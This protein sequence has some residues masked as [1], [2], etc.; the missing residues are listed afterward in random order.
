MKSIKELMANPITTTFLMLSL[1][2]SIFSIDIVSQMLNSAF[3]SYDGERTFYNEN[4]SIILK[5]KPLSLS[6]IKDIEVPF[7][8]E[9]LNH[10][11]A[12][13]NGFKKVVIYG[14]N[15]YG[16]LEKYIKTQNEKYFN[17]E[18]Y[19]GNE[20]VAIVGEL[21]KQLVYKKDGIEYIDIKGESFRVVDYISD[22]ISDWRHGIIIPVN[23]LSKEIY[24]EDGT[25]IINIYN[26]DYNENAQNILKEKYKG[27]SNIDKNI[28]KAKTWELVISYNNGFIKTAILGVLVGLINCIIS[29][30]F[31]TQ[32]LK[33]NIA[34]KKVLGARR[35][36]LVGDIFIKLIILNAVAFLIN[37]VLI[38][39]TTNIIGA[40]TRSVIEYSFM[41]S[42]ISLN[43]SLW[44]SLF[45]AI[46][47]LK[48]IRKISMGD[49]LR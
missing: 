38:N 25:N 29:S 30:I 37:I 40:V 26:T 47:L 19:R 33:K 20:N 14:V 49:N 44:I 8:T 18:D 27:F 22:K 45:I 17:Y 1:I 15:N 43:I 5:D 7:I 34:I 2:I 48:D 24:G 16:G 28:S 9:P 32:G 35:M 12:I 13:G 39:L 21:N 36:D 23:R 6:E 10:M 42:L 3:R 41:S 31:W 11:E 4:I 46:Y